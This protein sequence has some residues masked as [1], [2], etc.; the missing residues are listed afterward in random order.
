MKIHYFGHSAV[1]VEHA[2][3]LVLIDPFFTGS[4]WV[5][6]P[7]SIQPHTIMITHGHEDHVG[8]AVELSKKHGATVLGMWELANL[9]ESRGAKALPA[10][11]G[12]RVKHEWGWSKYVPAWHSSSNGGQYTGMPAGIV[13]EIGGRVFYHCGDTCV[14]SDMKLIA[15]LYKPEIAFLPI[16]GHF[17]MDVFEAVKAVEFIQPA[18]AIPLHY[19]TFDPIK[20]DPAEF[21]TA[22]ES[23]L[24]A[25]VQVMEPMSTWEVPAQVAR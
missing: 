25:K 4:P 10:G 12:G 18:F 23:K 17:T 16:G 7:P 3:H 21:K 24:R 5:K 11:L 13:F 15:E 1:A 19:N 6:S 20:Q 14:F 9:L 2:D 22:V 8:D